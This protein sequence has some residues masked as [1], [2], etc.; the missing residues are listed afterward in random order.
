MGRL[1]LRQRLR[2]VAGS[3]EGAADSDDIVVA[4]FHFTMEST[5]PEGPVEG[6]GA[7]KKITHTWL[8]VGSTWQIIGGMCGPLGEQGG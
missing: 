4:H 5:H 1:S 3:R 8:R 2:T 7:R 6:V